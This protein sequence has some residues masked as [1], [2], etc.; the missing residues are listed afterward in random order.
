[1]KQ[2]GI[3][4]ILIVILLLSGCGMN[5]KEKLSKNVTSKDNVSKSV[6]SKDAAINN[7][8]EKDTRSKAPDKST[9]QLKRTAA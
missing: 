6:I 8:P 1:M 3:V 9:V 5:R 4:L 7:K 2:K